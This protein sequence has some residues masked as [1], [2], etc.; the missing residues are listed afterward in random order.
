MGKN[1]V[2][3]GCIFI[4]NYENVFNVYISIYQY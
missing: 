2:V 4:I 3:E 1:V